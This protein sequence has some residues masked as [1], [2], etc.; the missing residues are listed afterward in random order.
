MIIYKLLCL[1]I[2]IIPIFILLLALEDFITNRFL[3]LFNCIISNLN[4]PLP[5]NDLQFMKNIKQL[6]LVLI[7][8]RFLVLLISHFVHTAH[9]FEVLPTAP[10]L[11]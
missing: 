1:K 9:F 5:I 11:S 4:R 7:F 6:I 8:L 3:A 10:I 2:S